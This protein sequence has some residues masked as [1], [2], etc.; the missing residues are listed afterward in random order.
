[1]SLVRLLRFQTMLTLPAVNPAQQSKLSFLGPG[2][3]AEI[4]PHA[5]L[6][7]LPPNSELLR[8]GQYVKV[9]PIVIS[10]LVK[11][12]SRFDDRDL[13]LYYIQPNES[14]VMSFAS[15]LNQEPSKVFAYTEEDSELLLLPT[16]KLPEWMKQFPTLNE[17]FFQQYNLRYSEML[18]TIHHLLFNKL[19]QRLLSYLREKSEL[20]GEN[21]LK[22]THK[23][24]AHEIGTV[25]E[26]VSRVMKR[27]E[28]EGKVEQE[29][30]TIRIAKW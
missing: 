2:A 6:V 21:P 30:N 7:T 1:M 12:I 8:E 5:Q 9:L 23:Q 15:G 25:R 11:V 20:R 18:D 22:I 26:V 27:L 29:G 3:A 13:L 14:C 10:G 4:F 28:S 16:D 24:I 19:D 17:L